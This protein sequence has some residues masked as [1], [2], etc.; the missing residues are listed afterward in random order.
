MKA[1]NNTIS[2]DISSDKDGRL[3]VWIS[4]EG[5]SGAHYE[6]KSAAE[7]GEYVADLIECLHEGNQ[8]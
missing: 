1:W 8:S 4:T 7:I 5:C 6:G 2:V 3:D